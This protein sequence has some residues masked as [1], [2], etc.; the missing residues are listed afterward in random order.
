VLLGSIVL[1]FPPTALAIRPVARLFLM[2]GAKTNVDL[3]GRVCTVTTGSV[4]D[5]F[6]QAAFEDGSLSL[7]LQVRQD[8]GTKLRKGARVLIVDWDAERNAFLIEPLDPI[9]EDDPKAERGASARNVVPNDESA[10]AAADEAPVE[11]AAIEPR[12]RARR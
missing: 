12:D 10:A 1:G 5:Y 6:G 4:N 3:V 7:L 9:L 11:Q 2:R 8:A